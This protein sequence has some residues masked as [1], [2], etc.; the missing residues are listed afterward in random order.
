MSDHT[1]VPD[2]TLPVPTEDKSK[3]GRVLVDGLNWM[4][5]AAIGGGFGFDSAAK[6]ADDFAARYPSREEAIDA[7]I[8]WQAARASATGFISNLGGLITLP[9]AIPANLG[10]VIFIQLN[11]VARIAHLR[12][13]EVSSDQVR[14]FA[15]ACLDRKSTRLNSS[16]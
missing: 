1:D 5:S 9:I 4:Y 7:L 12:G 10:A 3:A 2:E 11:M 8:N 6:A 16:H 13:Y 14:T 15:L